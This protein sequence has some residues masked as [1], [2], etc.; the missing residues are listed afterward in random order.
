MSDSLSQRFAYMVPSFAAGRAPLY[1]HLAGQAAAEVL[2][3]SSFA[4]A[5]EPF[6]EEPPRRLLPLRLMGVIHK[7]VLSGELPELA[8]YYPSAGG[9]GDPTGSW[10]LFRRAVVDRADRLPE[11]LAPPHR[12]NEV[13]RAAALS[14]GF[15]LLAHRYGMPLRLLEVGASAGLL[16]RWDRYLDRPWYAEMFE[17]GAP[18]V[19]PVAVAERA[20]CDLDPIDPLT[21]DGALTLKSLVWA[22]LAEHVA[23]LEE[24]IGIASSVPATVDRRDGAAWLAERLAA[25][26]PG[27]VTVVYHSLMRGAGP[28]ESLAGMRDVLEDASRRA[29]EDAPLAH[30]AFEATADLRELAPVPPASLVET[31]LAVWPGG[32]EE[33]LVTSDV[34]GRHVRW[35]RR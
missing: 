26:V 31:R 6:R 29:R 23:M 16:L 10:P 1:A 17:D 8:A 5:L 4:R 3:T 22:D 35:R 34:N 14:T 24:A 19:A 27:V 18:V 7:A 30:L 33:L 11:L 13:T 2:R 9:G 12:H 21:A 15:L 32:W 28:Q 25:P 20:G